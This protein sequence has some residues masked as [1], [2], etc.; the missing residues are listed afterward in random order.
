MGRIIP[1]EL[2]QTT[3]LK[4]QNDSL[5]AKENRVTEIA[6][7]YE[8]ILDSLSDDEKGADTVN[9]DNTAFVS[10]EIKKA[11]KQIKSENKGIKLDEES[12]EAK[13]IKVADLMAE[14]KDLKAKIKKETA[15]LQIK[16]KET[17][18]GL[19]DQQVLEL[20]KEKWIAPLIAALN[21]LPDNI[22]NELT[23][24]VKRLS[25]KYAITFSD[26]EN[27]IEKTEMALSSMIDELT[28]SDYDMKGLDELKSLFRGA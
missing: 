6:S 9:E 14:E 1:F 2:I 28:G 3:I 4:E 5:K 8:E 22:I 13:I 11:V 25:E 27:D 16:T 23:A 12:Y 17:I 7:T 18:E 26:V 19:S 20:L 15:E 10:A 24:K 21:N